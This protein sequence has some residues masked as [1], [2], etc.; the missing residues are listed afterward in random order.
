MWMPQKSLG[1]T[2]RSSKE[3]DSKRLKSAWIF[4]LSRLIKTKI[5]KLVE[6][7]LFPNFFD[8]WHSQIAYLNSVMTTKRTLYTSGSQHK[9]IRSWV[10]KDTF[11]LDRVK[12]IWY[13]SH[14]RAAK[15]QAS[16]RIR[17]VSPEPPLLART[18]NESRG[19]FRQKARSL[20]S[21]N[22]LACAVKICHDGMLEDTNSLDVAHFLVVFEPSFQD[23][24]KRFNYLAVYKQMHNRLWYHVT[25][26]TV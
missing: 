2:Q 11:D 19:T 24:E 26:H 21:L 6:T 7:L 14:M 22:G 4:S 10:R 13:L 20:A 17:V 12:R 15:V 8:K 5:K 23:A 3:S 25:K 1:K 9:G 16:L 18:S